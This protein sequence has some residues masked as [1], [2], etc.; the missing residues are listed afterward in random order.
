MTTTAMAMELFTRTP[1]LNGL[2]NRKNVSSGSRS[3]SSI[4]VMV[5]EC[6]LPGETVVPV[7]R[8]VVIMGI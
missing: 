4:T 8:M 7:R 5:N 6:Q 3:L 2:R 1:G